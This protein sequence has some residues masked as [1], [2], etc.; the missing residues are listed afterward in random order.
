MFIQS[1]QKEE[2][3]SKQEYQSI[4]EYNK[5]ILD[6]LRFEL[7]HANCLKSADFNLIEM[8]KTDEGKI[9]F[10][11]YCI[12][13]KIEI[14]GKEFIIKDYDPSLVTEL[15][16]STLV[17]LARFDG[18][19]LKSTQGL[20]KAAPTDAEIRDALLVEC[21]TY[22]AGLSEVCKSAVWIAYWLQ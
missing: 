18:S 21:G 4:E 2:I 10:S 17:K 6:A 8:L 11:V 15:Y 3:I 14:E 12:N 16:E 19:H 20:K 7:D 13:L 9:L 1:C 5:N 22:A